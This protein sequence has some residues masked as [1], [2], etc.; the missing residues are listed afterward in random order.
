MVEINATV[1]LPDDTPIVRVD[2][3]P[4]DAGMD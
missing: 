3:L 2:F 4:A 1:E